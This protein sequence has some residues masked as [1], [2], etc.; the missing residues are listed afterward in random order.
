MTQT[1]A[2]RC[3]IRGTA[4][5]RSADCLAPRLGSG[6]PRAKSSL[7]YSHMCRRLQLRDSPGCHRVC[8]STKPPHPSARCRC[9]GCA[10]CLSSPSSAARLARCTGP[11]AKDEEIFCPGE[12]PRLNGRAMEPSGLFS[13]SPALRQTLSCESVCQIGGAD[14]PTA[15]TE[16]S[17]GARKV[18]SPVTGST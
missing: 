14:L 16:S 10:L 3:T 2:G 1:N 13:G 7:T 18:T 8:P 9:G 17:G 4:A 5:T 11:S 15:S 6:E 12:G